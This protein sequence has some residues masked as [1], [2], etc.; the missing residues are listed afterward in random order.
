MQEEKDTPI[1]LPLIGVIAVIIAMFSG[2]TFIEILIG[3][4]IFAFIAWLIL[5][6]KD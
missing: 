6:S 3:I 1:W 5:P 4:G 2:A